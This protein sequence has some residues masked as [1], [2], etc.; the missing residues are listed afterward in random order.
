MVQPDDPDA[1]RR[2]AAF[3]DAHAAWMFRYALM[4]LGDH[5]SAEDVMQRV[6][7]KLIAMRAGIDEIDSPP[8]YLRKAVRREALRKLLT[9]GET[10]PHP[11]L[12][13][14]DSAQPEDGTREELEMALRQLP[15]EQREVIH[16]KVYEEL[17]F[18]QIA[19]VQGTSPNTAAS[20]YRYAMEKLRSFLDARR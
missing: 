10:P 1:H 2:I 15:P 6:F 7:E 19:Q 11:L 13:A 12:E 9:T 20:R 16:L 4:I 14:V 17:T 8:A 18:Q 5:A 3:Y